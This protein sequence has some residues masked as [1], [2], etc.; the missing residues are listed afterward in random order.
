MITDEQLLAE[1][2][3]ILEVED[4]STVTMDASLDELGWDSLCVL[5]FIGFADEKLGKTISGDALRDC[6]TVGDLRNLL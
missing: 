2:A 6:Q 1:V 3:E 4:E 5:S